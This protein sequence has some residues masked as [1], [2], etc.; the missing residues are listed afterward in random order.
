MNQ[1]VF[2]MHLIHIFPDNVKVHVHHNFFLNLLHTIIY[3]S[4]FIKI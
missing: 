1:K 4:M 2:N 3:Y